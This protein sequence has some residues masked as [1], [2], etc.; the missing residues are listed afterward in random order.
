MGNLCGRE[1]DPFAQPGRRLDSAPAT[2]ASASVP[3]T[4][5]HRKP[6]AASVGGTPHTLGGSTG[7]RQATSAS[8]PADDARARAAAAAEERLSRSRQGG[9]KLKTQLD[10]ERGKTGTQLLQDASAAARGYRT[11]DQS[12]GALAHS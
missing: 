11:M 3:T 10:R 5:H 1:S 9:G 7:P 8:T 6:A 2:P 4:A 12:T